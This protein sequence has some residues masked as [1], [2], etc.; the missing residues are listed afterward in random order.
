MEHNIEPAWF[1][2]AMR[3]QPTRMISHSTWNGHI[4]F[5]AWIVAATKPKVIVE[6]GTHW[7][8]SYFAM[9]QAVG[10]YAQGAQCFGI[11][12][13][14][15]DDHAGTYDD[16]VYRSVAEFNVR[17]AEFSTLLR[18]TFD[19]AL[20]HF[21]NGSIDLLHI[22]GLHTYDAVRHDF[23][24]WLPKMSSSG[25]VLFHDTNEHG[26]DFG[27]WQLWDELKAKYATI[28]FMHSYGLGV[29]FLGQT[30]TPL[31]SALLRDAEQARQLFLNQAELTDLK[32][33]QNRWHGQ[34]LGRK[35]QHMW[36]ALQSSNGG[37]RIVGRT[38]GI[39]WREG[40]PGVRRRFHR[41]GE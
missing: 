17:Y 38:G 3:M 5:A 28:E 41:L 32:S 30:H 16:S 27:V 23:E 25:V 37:F 29:L 1:H 35:I 21:E 10:A 2:P 13:W 26:R 8:A 4:P 22:D 39:F 14:A 31:V 19:R 9:C 12:T 20:T 7:G 34:P 11:D 33:A 18:S 15:G 24:T 6:L 40:W 36:A